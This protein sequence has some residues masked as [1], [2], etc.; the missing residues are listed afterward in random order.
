MKNLILLIL[1][2]FGTGA[3]AGQSKM[4][5]CDGGNGDW[6]VLIT[7]Q[8]FSGT[9]LQKIVVDEKY[10]NQAPSILEGEIVGGTPNGDKI[11]FNL[12]SLS[13]HWDVIRLRLPLNYVQTKKFSGKYTRI[14]HG[15]DEDD[16]DPMYMECTLK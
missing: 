12:D 3:H 14:F 15:T 10:K 16:A 1:F 5:N 9:H 2:L 8:V 11:E 13:D 7:A 6:H 4:L